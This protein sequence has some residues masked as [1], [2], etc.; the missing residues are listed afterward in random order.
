ML[1][2]LAPHYKL[3]VVTKCSEESGR[4]AADL[5]GEPFDV[6]V[7]SEQTGFYKPDPEPYKLA[8]Q[9]ADGE[10]AHA[11][12]VAGSA[13]DLFG[14]QRVGLPSFWRNRIGLYAPAGAPAPLI[15]RVT[16]DSRFEDCSRSRS[17]SQSAS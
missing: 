7:T 6:I 13:Y 14:T 11:I 16:L 15:M 17:Q 12:F 10:A 8:L 4:I 2:E 5:L 3:G 1:T 9:V